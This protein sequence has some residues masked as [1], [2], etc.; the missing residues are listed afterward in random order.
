M[1][2]PKRIPPMEIKEEAIAL[3]SLIQKYLAENP[4]ENRERMSVK[5]GIKGRGAIVYQHMD[6][7][8]PI[9][10]DAG[11]AY[12]NGFSTPLSTISKRLAL[13]ASKRLDAVKG[14]EMRHGDS[15]HNISDQE[16]HLLSIFRSLPSDSE[17]DFFIESMEL[18]VIKHSDSR[19]HA[20]ISKKMKGVET[21]DF[22]PKPIKIKLNATS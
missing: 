4:D 8:T 16:Q 2:R 18:K 3:T 21:A 7:R 1:S 19:G 14:D 20:T 22:A 10:M 11:I 13:E 5:F 15:E 6:G 17:R 9:S 12:S